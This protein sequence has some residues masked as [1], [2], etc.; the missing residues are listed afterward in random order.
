VR[1][2]LDTYGVDRLK[3][4]LRHRGVRTLSRK[5]LRFWTMRLGLE[6]EACFERSSPTRSRAFWNY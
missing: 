5:T 3:D 2:L 4:V 1:W 6:E